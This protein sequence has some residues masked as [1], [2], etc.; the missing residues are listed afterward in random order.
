MSPRGLFDRED[1]NDS[2]RTHCRIHL[3]YYISVQNPGKTSPGTDRPG[4]VKTAAAIRAPPPKP[5]GRLANPKLPRLLNGN[6]S[7]LPTCPSCQRAFRVRIGLVGHLRTQRVI[8]PATSSSSPIPTLSAN[9]TPTA[10]P[11]TVDHTVAAP[12]PPPAS[13][14]APIPASTAAATVTMNSRTPPIVWTTSV[15]PSPSSITTNTPTS[16][17]VDS[18]HT[19]HHCDCT[20]T[21]HIGLV[22]QLRIPRTETGEPVPEAPI[23][24]HRMGQFGHIRTHES[25]Q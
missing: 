22:G 20:S 2:T 1:Q 17:D 21:L 12:P 10:T 9:S 15:A 11:V 7:P 23:Y 25:L 14:P 19:C 24:T 13:A 16:S 18:V 6:R 5:N 3:S 4:K 8:N